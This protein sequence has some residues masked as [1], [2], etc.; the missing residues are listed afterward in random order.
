MHQVNHEPMNAKHKSSSD[1][2][3]SYSKINHMF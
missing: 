2:Q 1:P 3:V